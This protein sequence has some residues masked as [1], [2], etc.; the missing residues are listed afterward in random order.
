VAHLG[1]SMIIG[2]TNELKLLNKVYNS[3]EAEFLVVYGRRRVGKTYLIHEFFSN[4]KCKLLHATGLQR[5]SQKKQLKKF[6]EA[7]SETFLDNIALEVP[8]GWDEAFSV[9]HKQLSKYQEKT[10]IFLDEL[11]WMATRR[12]GLLEEIDYYWNRNW[13]KMP[14]VILALCGSSASWLITKIINNKGGLH[15][16]VTRS[17]KLLPFNLFET[18]E[19]LKS[20]NINLNKKHVLSLYMALGGVPYYLKYIERGLTAEQNIQNIFFTKDAPLLNEFNKLFESLFENSDA[21]IEL[22]HLIAQRKEGVRRV[23]LKIDARLSSGGG[24]LSKRLQ[25]LQEAGFIEENIPWGHSTGESYKLID[26]FCLFY[27][28]WVGSQKQKKF[29]PNYWLNQSQRPSYYAWSGYA[30]EAVCM[31]HIDHIIHALNIK[32]SEQVSSCRFIPRKNFPEGTQIDLVID[33][34]DNAVT[35]CEIKYSDQKY[36][37]DKQYAKNLKR[38]IE[39]FK[40]RTRTNKQIFLAMICAN[41][42]KKTKYSED[43]IDGGVVTLDDFF[44]K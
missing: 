5:G 37:I 10:V 41:G 12:S 25:D 6:S 39:I 24:R 32:A 9:L 11:P 4:K 31:K 8:K 38:K 43:Q 33:R 16:R 42:L 27:L 44:I 34:S 13:S 2:R 28:Q 19:F 17:I 26:E 30:F 14:N 20:R 18:N 35:I 22:I 3:H 23:E 36:A 1:I 15:N 21:Y 40:T 7:I 29:T